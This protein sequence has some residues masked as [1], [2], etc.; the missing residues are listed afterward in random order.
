VRILSLI[1]HFAHVPQW[2]TTTT[3]IDTVYPDWPTRSLPSKAFLI[4]RSAPSWDRN[5]FFYD[6]R[7]PL[8]VS[9]I[10]LLLHPHGHRRRMVFT[11]FLCDTTRLE[12]AHFSIGGLYLLARWAYFWVFV[13]LFSSVVVHSRAEIET[14]SRVF[15]VPQSRFV[16]V[17]YFVR[18]DAFAVVPCSP[19]H[20]MPRERY[21]VAAG[22]HRDYATFIEA[23]SG[24]D[25]QAVIVAGNDDAEMIR[26]KA[27][28]AGVELRIEVPFSEYRE[29]IRH[30]SIC[31][32]PLSSDGPV[33]SL[34]QI[35]TFEAI[36]ARTPVIAARTSQLTDYFEED[37]EIQFYKPGD[38]QDLRAKI[39]IVMSNP[40]ASVDRAD[41]AFRRVVREYTAAEYTRKLIGMCMAD[42]TEVVQG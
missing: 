5:V 2:E 18:D 13:R 1:T 27:A 20:A 23:V 16:F 22:R 4:A 26:D 38:P 33:R 12:S 10:A 34:G 6:T 39:E 25:I 15:G 9:L 30:A 17:P 3:R 11:T 28:A 14:Y 42:M 40:C 32:V 21:V 41:S 36:A 24:L 29:L 35:A 7:L 31:V 37:G 8:V 19:G